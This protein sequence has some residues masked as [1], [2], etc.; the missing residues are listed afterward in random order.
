MKTEYEKRHK[1]GLDTV[2]FGKSKKKFTNF[3][4]ALAV[5]LP[6][7]GWFVTYLIS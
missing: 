5:L 2:V 7:L 3:Y 4:T 1:Y 6:L